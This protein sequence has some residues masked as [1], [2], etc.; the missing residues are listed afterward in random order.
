[1]LSLVEIIREWSAVVDARFADA[2]HGTDREAREMELH[3]TALELYCELAELTLEH[4]AS[5]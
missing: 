4:L 1:L 3:T 5:E 2:V